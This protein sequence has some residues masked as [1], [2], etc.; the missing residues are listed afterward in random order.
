MR[1]DDEMTEQQVIDD[2]EAS[3]HWQAGT[4]YQ[5]TDGLLLRPATP[6]HPRPSA[7]ATPSRPSTHATTLD[8]PPMPRAAVGSAAESSVLVLC[9]RSFAASPAAEHSTADAPFPPALSP[10]S[11]RTSR[12]VEI[13]SGCGGD[14]LAHASAVSVVE[15][16]AVLLPRSPK[17]VCRGEVSYC[18]H[19]HCGR[20][21]TYG[22]CGLM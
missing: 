7:H 2:L 12:H 5:S 16:P 9:G 4:A 15:D 18:H 17:L 20:G 13:V 19:G 8:P 3:R 22:P 21:R 1:H 11:L 6:A 10:E 14:C